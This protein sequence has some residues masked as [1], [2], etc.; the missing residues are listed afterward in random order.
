MSGAVTTGA[1]IR[2]EGLC[3]TFGE[4]RRAA[5][6]LRNVSLTVPAGSIA[7]VVGQSGCGKSTFLRVLAGLE[8]TYDGSVLLGKQ[9][10]HGPGL[11]RGVVFQEHRLLPWLTVE[12]N[13]AF[14]LKGLSRYETRRC[15]MRCL[16]RVGLGS[17]ARQYPYLLSGGMAQRVAIARALVNQP[18]ILLL[19]EP[20]G[21]LDAL[22]KL[23][24]QQEILALW[25]QEK[26]TLVLVTHDIDEAVFL[27]DR[28]VVMAP[29]G[30]QTVK[31][32][33]DVA[34][35]R[36]RDRNAAAFIALR[37]EILS[38]LFD[39]EKKLRRKA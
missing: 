32:T 37:K 31:E 4:G 27:A 11:D 9:P 35:P 1:D 13:V 29:G 24:M 18:K 38:F 21:A 25:E 3:K 36:P 12:Q 39:Q 14:A 28:I 23:Q 5:K 6:V 16:K 7:C 15:V 30:A 10:L 17:C 22:T 26:T 8:T 20:F 2:I 19:D 34:L 33:I